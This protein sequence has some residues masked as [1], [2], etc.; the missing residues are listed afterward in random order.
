M[1]MWGNG[2]RPGVF[3]DVIK[4]T[5]QVQGCIMA[6][7]DLRTV[8]KAETPPTPQPCLWSLLFFNPGLESSYQLSML[9]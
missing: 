2:S 8:W 5:G 6:E 3:A 1:E 7:L 4:A 9:I